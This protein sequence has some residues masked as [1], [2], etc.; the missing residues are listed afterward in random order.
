MTIKEQKEKLISELSLISDSPALEANE[1]IIYATN[2]DR[3][4]ILYKQGQNLSKS[5]IK[6]INRCLLKRKKGI[7]LQYIIGEWEF[8]SLPFKVGKGVLIPRADSEL[9]VD[10]VLEELDKC[11]EY[12]VLDL[13]SG[14]GA[15]GIAVAK[16]RNNATV[17]LVEKSRKAFRYL[18][19]NVKL[20]AAN[21]TAVRGDI[22][23][24]KPENA[25]DIVI[26]N[27]PY[28]TKKEMRSLQKEVKKEPTAALLGGKDG[29]KF[30]RLLC[31]KASAFLKSGGKIFVE[32]GYEQAEDVIGLFESAGFEKVEC[33][34]DL[35]GND[36]V[37]AATYK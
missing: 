14:S 33:F 34:K 36:R 22:F 10:L 24:W 20:N 11:S 16:N 27:P 31:N 17:T 37:V 35:N 26:C 1:I 5:E 9:L 6:T 2:L 32:I 12:S 3:S 23:K 21:L 30:Y 25:A 4:G 15:L 19:E 28:I 18:R 7:P 29:L 8:Y 13:C